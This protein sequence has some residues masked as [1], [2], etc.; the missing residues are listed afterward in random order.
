MISDADDAR[1]ILISM[2][3][4]ANGL[5]EVP[6]F[7][8]SVT[9]T[10]TSNVL[11]HATGLEKVPRRYDFRLVFPGY[12]DSLAAETGLIEAP[13][14]LA[15]LRETTLINQRAIVAPLDDGK[16]WSRALRAGGVPSSSD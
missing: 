8:H 10:C 4:T 13:D 16:A 14:G 3:E 1:A 12:A 7:Y 2:L 5:A 9:N 11:V 15:A 6:E